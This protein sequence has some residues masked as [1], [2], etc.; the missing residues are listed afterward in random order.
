MCFKNLPVEFDQQGNATLLKNIPNPY[1][2]ETVSL[3]GE[4]DKLKELLARNGFIKNVDFDP[5]TRVAG[6]L[7]FHTVADLENRKILST[8]SMAT[9]FRG[10]EIILR[11]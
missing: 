5:V 2:Y 10:Y 4:Q 3:E 7:A 8:N 1:E 6:A 11:S 9:L